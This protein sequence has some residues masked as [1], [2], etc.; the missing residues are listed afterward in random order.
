MKA[1]AVREEEAAE[2]AEDEAEDEAEGGG[3]SKWP[4]ASSRSR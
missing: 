4:Y 1:E 2:E 3:P